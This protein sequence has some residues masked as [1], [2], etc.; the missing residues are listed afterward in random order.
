MAIRRLQN[1]YKEYIKNPN[2]FYSI[3][4]NPNNFLV[5]NILLFGPTDTI[6]EGLTL[7]CRMTFPNNYPNKPPSFIFTENI[8]HPN[9]YSDGRVCI[10][11]LHEGVDEFGYED[12][13]ER[14]NP[15]QSVNSI[16]LSIISM[17]PDPNFESPANIN[18]SV[19]W[20]NNFSEYKS[21]IYKKIAEKN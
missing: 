15:S 10:S 7:N 1:E 13:S 5:W 19:M 14:W 16:L 6:F 11:I 4:I 18:A 21:I 20:Q 2:E 17:L 9:I 3:E 12:V 8:F